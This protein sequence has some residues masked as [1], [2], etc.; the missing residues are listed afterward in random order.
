[1]TTFDIGQ[2]RL[3]NQGINEAAFDTPGQVVTHLLAVQAQDYPGALWAVGL[4]MK[5]ATPAI[6]EQAIAD[7]AIVRTWP[8]RGTLHFVAAADAR[9]MLKLLTPRVIS[10][11]SARHR[12]L[13]IDET[14]LGRSKEL[15]SQALAGG[16]QITRVEMFQ[17]LER[18]N[19]SPTGQRGPHILGRL[20]QEGFLCF[21]SHQDKQ[22]TFALLDEWLP[23]TRELERDE[24]LAELAKR[25][26]TGHGPATVADLER[27][28]GLKI[29]EARAGFEMVKSQLQHKEVDGQTYWLPQDEPAAG[30]PPAVHLL[31][32]FDEYILGYKDRSAVLEPQYSE[33]IVPGNNG[34]FMSTIV[35]S[36]K[37]VGTWKRTIKK[38]KIIISPAPFTSLSKAETKGLDVA[39]ERYGRFMSMAVEVVS[40]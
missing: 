33:K 1:M 23:P 36:G 17:V 2:Y 29:S 24:A 22:P 28:A 7:R 14:V 13:E 12:E 3:Y 21:G 32:G 39:A 16:K 9:W 34:M 15:F 8:M 11:M 4:R 30:K 37:V 18:G 19:I 20:S 5:K 40:S 6:I 25:Y 26:F 31:P 10:G 38:D 27:W 35:S